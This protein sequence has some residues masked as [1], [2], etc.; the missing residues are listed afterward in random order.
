MT[1]TIHPAP[2]S[3]NPPPPPPPPPPPL[4]GDD[5]LSSI[6]TVREIVELEFSSHSR[7][8]DCPSNP[9]SDPAERGDHSNND[10]RT[11]DDHEL[12]GNMGASVSFSSS[13]PLSS[14]STTS[15]TTNTA[16]SWRTQLYLR[17]ED[18]VEFQSRIDR[19]GGHIQRL[20]DQLR[21][22]ERAASEEQAMRATL[23]QSLLA[24]HEQV[25]T[26]TIHLQEAR[27]GR[28]ALEDKIRGIVTTLQEQQTS[29]ER[30]R[31]NVQDLIQALREEH[32]RAA[33]RATQEEAR[34]VLAEAQVEELQCQLNLLQAELVELS[35]QQQGWKQKLHEAEMAKQEAESKVTKMHE[36]LQELQHP[37]HETQASDSDEQKTDLAAVV[38]ALQVQI[39]QQ[40]EQKARDD[41]QSH[42]TIAELNSTVKEYEQSNRRLQE[43]YDEVEASRTEAVQEM[44]KLI[45]EL[46]VT[47]RLTSRTSVPLEGGDEV[48]ATSD[49]EET[50]EE[51]ETRL[52]EE[53]FTKV[54]NA[55]QSLQAQI[56][57]MAK[58]QPSRKVKEGLATKREEIVLRLEDRRA[59]LQEIE[60]CTTELVNAARWKLDVATERMEQARQAWFDIK[61][62]LDKALA[63]GEFTFERDNDSDKEVDEEVEKGRALLEAYQVETDRTSR[64][65]KTSKEEWQRCKNQLRDTLTRLERYRY[66]AELQ[67]HT[68][69]DDDDDWEGNEVVTDTVRMALTL[70][71]MP[72]QQP[73]NLKTPPGDDADTITDDT[74]SKIMMGTNNKRG[75]DEGDRGSK[76]QKMVD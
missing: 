42:R 6:R 75:T 21:R 20:Q 1:F 52:L 25:Q 53:R 22:S 2:S 12:D 57:V 26:L 46:E 35:N 31:T 13:T 41:E 24:H 23:E 19:Q 7:S 51:G 17:Y 72:Q 34:R 67:Q 68:T 69:Q 73:D 40:E 76:R 15:T 56:A 3:P 10:D 43:M 27:E 11:A 65:Y 55:V 64:V 4:D 18:R 61:K 59:I 58:A 37:R 38:E 49:M 71:P 36:R 70:L 16:S 39:R 32:D 50:H 54:S 33:E 30:E 28:Q 62:R 45:E 44:E 48:G 5:L 63:S 60:D 9:I 47:K 29:V 66:L 14:S 74:D 8:Q